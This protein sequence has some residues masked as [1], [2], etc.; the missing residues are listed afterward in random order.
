MTTYRFL[1]LIN[2]WVK[3]MQNVIPQAVQNWEILNKTKLSRL[4]KGLNVEEEI[5]SIF[6]VSIH[7]SFK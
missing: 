1:H 5:F 2:Y 7:F 3:S 4:F 6:V